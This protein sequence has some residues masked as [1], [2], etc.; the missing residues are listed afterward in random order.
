MKY[1]LNLNERAF[2]AIINKTKRIEIRT[3]TGNTDYSKMTN[4][5]YKPVFSFTLDPVTMKRIRAYNDKRTFLR[6]RHF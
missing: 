6:K 5:T 1:N 4:T 3:I 2:N